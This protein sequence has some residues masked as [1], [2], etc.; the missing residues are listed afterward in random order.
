MSNN[1]RNVF[2]EVS[3]YTDRSLTGAFRIYAQSHGLP[4][5]SR[6]LAGLATFESLREIIQKHLPLIEDGGDNFLYAS[7]TSLVAVSTGHFTNASKSVSI[8][9]CGE[10]SEEFVKTLENELKPLFTVEEKVNSL[11]TLVQTPRGISLEHVTKAEFDTL[12]RLNYS[13][14]VLKSYD[15]IVSCFK[16]T[17]PC[18]RIVLLDGPPGT[19]KSYMIRSL[20]KDVLGT[21]ILVSP[22][23]VGQLTGPAVVASLL[24]AKE[25]SETKPVILIIEDADDVL[26]KRDRGHKAG[27]S[28]LLNLGD[29]LLG[30]IADVRIIATT[31][32]E[33]KNLDPAVVRPGRMCSRIHTNELSE[34]QA[35]A[36]HQHLVGDDSNHPKDCPRFLADIYRAARKDGWTSERKKKPE[37]GQY[38]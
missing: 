29:G 16:S 5:V 20:T 7:D 26:V 36:I 33:I 25:E 27:L 28:E 9:S 37:A 18:G 17:D 13:P 24:E 3:F 8:V 22:N 6:D 11:Y 2:K 35:D 14:E 4:V 21:F 1:W 19:G 12:P 10:G 30:Q 15:H 38:L 34:S 32:A 31:N 23:V